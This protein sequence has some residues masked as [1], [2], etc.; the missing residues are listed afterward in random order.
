[1]ERR[2]RYGFNPHTHAG[3]DISLAVNIAPVGR[4]NPHT[5]AGCDIVGFE[6]YQCS[7]VSIHTPTQGVTIHKRA[8]KA[9]MRVFQSTHPRRVWPLGYVLNAIGLCFN[10]HTH[11]GCDSGGRR[12]VRWGCCFN[13]HTHAGCDQALDKTDYPVSVSIHTPTQGVTNTQ[14]TNKFNM[15]VS[16]HTPTQGVTISIQIL[17]SIYLFQSTHP[18]RVWLFT[19]FFLKIR[20]GFNPHTHAGCDHLGIAHFLT[21]Y[22]FNPHTHAGC[23]IGRFAFLI[24]QIVSIHTPT[25]GVT[26]TGNTRS[27]G[28]ISFQSTHPRR[29]WLCPLR[30]TQQGD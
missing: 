16:I 18:R 3:C 29:V 6:K 26:S 23:D 17:D 19:F 27:F 4:F 20:E 1:M 9:S 21:F 8:K 10:P 22:R 5:H 7:Q 14:T 15:Q 11:A 13:P 2:L 25:Q 24:R 12:S 30:S 28:F